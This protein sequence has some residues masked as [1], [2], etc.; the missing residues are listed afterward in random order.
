MHEMLFACQHALGDEYLVKYANDLGLNM[1]RFLWNFSQHVYS[2]RVQSDFRSGVESG[3]TGTPTFFINNVPLEDSWNLKALMTAIEKFR[4][5]RRQQDFIHRS[6]FRVYSGKTM[7]QINAAEFVKN[8]K[9]NVD[10]REQLKKA[11]SLDHCV[12]IADQK[13]F[14]FTSAELQTEFSQLSPEEVAEIINPGIYPRQHIN[15]A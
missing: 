3:V 14:D 10:L 1:S 12:E 8:A 11:M 6:I 5:S 2:D 13:G 15:P 7:S 9:Q 4:P